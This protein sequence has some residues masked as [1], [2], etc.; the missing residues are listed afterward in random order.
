MKIGNVKIWKCKFCGKIFNTVQG[1]S[2]HLGRT[3]RKIV[4]DKSIS[5]SERA[6]K[7]NEIQNE[8]ERLKKFYPRWK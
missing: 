6:E 2:I 5:G 7:V 1:L 4:N 8:K 3:Q